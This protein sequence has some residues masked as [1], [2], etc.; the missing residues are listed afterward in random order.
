MEVDFE[1]L[2]RLGMAESFFSQLAEQVETGGARP[3]RLPL[4]GV[5]ILVGASCSISL[6][7]SEKQ[8]AVGGHHKDGE[9]VDG[10]VV[11]DL[12]V[13]QADVLLF[14]TM[15]HF[16]LPAINGGLHKDLDA[17]VKVVAEEEG[18]LSVIGFAVH[19]EAI[20]NGS[21]HDQTQE[22]RACPSLPEHP[23]SFLEPNGSLLAAYEELFLAPGSLVGTDIF[24]GELDGIIDARWMSRIVGSD[25]ELG[26]FAASGED[27]EAVAVGA[28]D[29]AIAEAAIKDEQQQAPCGADKIVLLA[30]GLHLPDGLFAH[31]VVFS[32]ALVC[33]LFLGRGFLAGFAGEM[34]RG[35]S[36]SRQAKPMKGGSY[37]R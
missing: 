32:G 27:A 19:G 25:T 6:Q 30:Q 37:R 34:K 33:G 28:E 10:G 1:M 20:G 24:G 17:Q 7:R 18:G 21:D 13:L 4:G 5:Y 29:G 11:P 12:G 22:L 3:S 15:V 35:R 9:A 2:K 26:I 31:A 23:T 16:D 14:I 8:E 36:E